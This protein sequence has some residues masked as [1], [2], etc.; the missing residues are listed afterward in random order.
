MIREALITDSNQIADI[1]VKAWQNAYEGIIDPEYPKSMSVNKFID[2]FSNNITLKTETVFVYEK[3][4]KV[5]GFISGIIVKK[6]YDSEVIGLYIDP[7]FQG[8]GIG[9]KLLKKI[10]KYFSSNNCSS[11]IIWT[12]EG[13]KNN[14]FYEKHGG[15]KTEKKKLK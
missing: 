7:E 9:S 14:S 12:L 6:E 10:K 5:I 15:R 2:I 11:M 4:K 8:K 1:I 3:D 13:A